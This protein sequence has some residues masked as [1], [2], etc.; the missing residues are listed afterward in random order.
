VLSQGLRLTIEYADALL[1]LYI[2][3]V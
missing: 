1:N 2:H 3:A